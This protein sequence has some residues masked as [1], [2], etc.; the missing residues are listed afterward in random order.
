MSQE[1]VELTR[2]IFESF[3]RHGW[4]GMWRFADE[5]AVFHEPPEQPGATVFEGLDAAR[6][7]IERSWRE[8]W[9]EQRSD[10]ERCEDLG[11]RVLVLTVEH[12]IGRNGIEV[13][14]PCGHILTFRAGKV[15]R[16]EGFWD[17]QNALRA[18]GLSEPG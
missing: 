13:T 9:V 14:Q 1:D 10:V 12:L 17:Q 5:E 16:Y 6:E 11:D 18:A 3:N 15:V 4:D 8:N 7:G 2:T